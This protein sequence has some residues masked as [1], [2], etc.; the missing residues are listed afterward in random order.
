MPDNPNAMEPDTGPPTF[1][2][3]TTALPMVNKTQRYNAQG[4][5]PGGGGQSAFH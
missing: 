1:T 5:V 4:Y 3:Q 2:Q